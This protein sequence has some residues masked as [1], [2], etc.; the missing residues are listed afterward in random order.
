MTD[1]RSIPADSV[2]I[3][4]A[5][6]SFDTTSRNSNLPL[7]EWIEEY[8]EHHGV[9]FTRYP[10]GDDGKWNL[11]AFIG[12][13]EAGGIAFS[14]HLDT[15]PVDGQDWTSDPFILRE[16]NGRL[17]GRGAADMKGYVACMLAAIP[18]I[19]AME[20]SRPVHLLFTCDEEITC[21]GA[22]EL[23]ADLQKAGQVPALCVVGEPSLMTP[24]IAHK[25]RFAVRVKLTGKS[26]HSS[27]PQHG[28]NALHA[29]GRAIAICADQAEW[30]ATQGRRVEGFDPPY[31]SMQV[32]LAAGGAILNIIPE[33]AWFDVEWRNVPGDEGPQALEHLQSALALLD[34]VLRND[35]PQG[36]ITYEMLVDLP[37]LSLSEEHLLTDV[38]RQIT[39]SNTTGYVSYGT[40]AGIY[41]RGGMES[42]VCGPGD[43]AQAHR[44][45]EFI[46][47]EQLQRCDRAIRTFAR[48]ISATP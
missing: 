30:F 9:R 33:H 17:Y 12:P 35:N 28:R 23:I 41:Q 8:L 24:I 32:G 39:G 21:N 22:R 48:R 40:E 15:V 34:A 47:I 10:G 26:G 11:H 3:L 13:D 7:V 46:A 42:I 6:V 37:P 29:M 43:I 44:P 31:T 27:G 18:D 19:Q 38:T 20:L 14:G 5:L 1:P 25:G 45:D 16:E 2:A 4:S 36:G